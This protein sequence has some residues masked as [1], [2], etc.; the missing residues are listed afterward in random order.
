MDI[1]LYLA[2]DGVTMRCLVVGRTQSD[3]IE[4]ARLTPEMLAKLVFKQLHVTGPSSSFL[5]KITVGT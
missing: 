3:H 5:F 1:I 4:G 2:V